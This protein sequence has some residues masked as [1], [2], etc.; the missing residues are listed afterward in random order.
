[1]SE[2]RRVA[3]VEY[4]IWRARLHDVIRQDPGTPSPELWFAERLT[5]PRNVIVCGT[6]TKREC[7]ALVEQDAGKTKTGTAGVS[8]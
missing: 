8:A 7:I 3:G 5:E 1:M 2:L 6:S 4:V